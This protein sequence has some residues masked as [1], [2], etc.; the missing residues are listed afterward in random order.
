MITLISLYVI[1]MPLALLLGFKFERGVPGFWLGFLMA[2]IICDIGVGFV[3]I[4]ARW[5][6]VMNQAEDEGNESEDSGDV[7]K[8]YVLEE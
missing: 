4:T 7:V 3:V 5:T 8:N 6:P 2:L 1:G